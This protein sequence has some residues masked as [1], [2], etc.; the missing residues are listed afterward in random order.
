MHLSFPLSVLEIFDLRKIVCDL[1]FFW[2]AEYFRFTNN[3]VFWDALIQQGILENY[4]TGNAHG[5]NQSL[6]MCTNL[7]LVQHI[8]IHRIKMN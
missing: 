8:D 2:F 5:G 4:H 6:I 7:G 1:L 3:S